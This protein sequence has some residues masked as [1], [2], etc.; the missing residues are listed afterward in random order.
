MTAVIL[1]TIDIGTNSV[2]LLVAK[3]E[4]GR[5]TPIEERVVITRLGEGV[6]RRGRI[7]GAAADRTLETLAQFRDSAVRHD[8]RQ[9]VA[10]GTRVLRAAR[11]AR[12]FLLRCEYEAGLSARILSAE[13]EARL[14]FLAA[15]AGSDEATVIDIGGGSTQISKGTR[16]RLEGPWSMNLG[17]VVLTER[18]LL[19]D[20]PLQAEMGSVAS[21]IA[22]ALA[23]ILRHRP[24]PRRLIGVGGTVATA[25]AIE[26]RRTATRRDVQGWILR[27]SNVESLRERLAS[28]TIEERRRVPGLEPARADI[29]VA[30][31]MILETVLRRGE[32]PHVRASAHGIRHALALELASRH[33]R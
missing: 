2:K 20:P 19:H 27:K 6:S 17:A 18:Y 1:A 29:I 12:D 3:I 9:I 33:R 7:A 13:E 14:S 31:L 22:M 5:L 11:N 25:V 26:R 28:L 15:A 24:F 4:R 8:A 32:F 23:P 21:R 16:G 10:V 30:G